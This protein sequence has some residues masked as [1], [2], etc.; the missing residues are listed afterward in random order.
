MYQEL[1]KTSR[2]DEVPSGV[3]I[4]GEEVQG[5]NPGHLSVQ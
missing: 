3:S 2:L 4:D 5:K 1:F